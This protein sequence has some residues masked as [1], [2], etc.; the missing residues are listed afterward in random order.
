MVRKLKSWLKG[1]E[2]IEAPSEATKSVAKI[3][4]L[5]PDACL[6]SGEKTRNPDMAKALRITWQEKAAGRPRGSQG[7]CSG[8]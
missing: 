4:T 6:S 3:G 2:T 7:C 8:T 1:I 5:S